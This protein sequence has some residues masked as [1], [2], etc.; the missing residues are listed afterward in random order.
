MGA[1]G[2]A[3]VDGIVSPAYNVYAPTKELDPTYIDALVRLRVFAQE[4][5]RYSM[6]VWS[7]RLR[8]YPDGFFAVNLPVPPVGEQQEIVRYLQREGDGIDTLKESVTLA[9]A[10]IVERR[11]A[12]IAGAVTGQIE[13]DQVS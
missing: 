10:L 4:V 6:G 8:P 5:T 12:L 13:V 11:S 1:M 7:S 3:F 9:H 2:V